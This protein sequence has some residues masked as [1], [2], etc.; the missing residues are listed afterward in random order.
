MNTQQKFE[1]DNE[2]L[3]NQLSKI[4]VRLDI[5][6]ENLNQDSIVRNILREKKNGS[7]LVNTFRQFVTELE[8]IVE[9]NR[10]PSFLN[11]LKKWID[12]IKN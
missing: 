9:E 10:K 2:D 11:D 5:V 6:Y 4:L 8:S 7:R 3:E 1:Q 12:S